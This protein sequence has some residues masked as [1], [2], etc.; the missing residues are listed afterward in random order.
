MS[1][2]KTTQHRVWRVLLLLG[3][4]A[5][6]AIAYYS[7]IALVVVVG[8]LTLLAVLRL[9]L[10]DKDRYIPNL[11]MQDIRVYDETYQNFIRR[12][13]DEL[14]RLK[15]PGHTLLWEAEQL[16]LS[17]TDGR[18]PLLL[19]LGVWI[20]WSTRLVHDASKSKVYGF[21]TFSGLV[22]DWK[23]EGKVV[24]QGSF[25]A[26][27]TLAK[28]TMRD[29]GVKF[30]DGVPSKNGRDVEFVKHSTYDT[31]VPFLVERPNAKVSLFHMDLDTY[32]S[33]LHALET[34]KERFVP[35]SILVFDEYLITNCEM[36]A[37]YEFQEKYDLKWE[38]R[39]WGLEVMEMNVEMTISTFK[40]F[41]NYLAAIFNFWSRG[42]GNQVWTFWRSRFRGFWLSAPIGDI[43][44]MF[45]AAGHRQS[46]SLEITGL[47]KLAG[48]PSVGDSGSSRPGEIPE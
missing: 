19:D 27:G 38:Y 31:L 1:I 8:L 21:D 14:R 30:V 41:W 39:A 25:S 35:G 32:E 36:R 22:E 6:L 47:G 3:I 15:I 20:G 24:K 16:D 48:A 33:C 26:A 11:Y 18:E 45:G 9:F 4:L 12:S 42:S 40:R 44:W 23:L 37:F 28:K 17:D 29:T 13:L 10:Y 5:V 46:V 7:F 2:D 43:A 34:C